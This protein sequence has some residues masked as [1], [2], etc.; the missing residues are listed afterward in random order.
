M[1]ISIVIVTYNSEETINR[2]I[3]SIIR[4]NDIGNELE[5]IVSDNN[6]L[7]RGYLS[8]LKSHFKFENLQVI[9]NPRNGGFGYGNNRGINVSKGDILFFLNPDTVIK[10]ISFRRIIKFYERNNSLLTFKSN[11]NLIFNPEIVFYLPYGI[12]RDLVKNLIIKLLCS[13]SKGYTRIPN[14]FYAMG[15]AFAIKKEVFASIG[16]FDEELF[17]YGE[18]LS[19]KYRLQDRN[20]YSL[21][22]DNEALIVHEGGVSTGKNENTEKYRS[23]RDENIS[24]S[25]KVNLIKYGKRGVAKRMLIGYK[26]EHLIRRIMSKDTQNVDNKIKLLKDIIKEF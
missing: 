24:K 8:G 25:M 22:M 7:N 6:P 1:R 2:C 19:I 5:I 3:E 18:E 16:F 14:I 9:L 23:F 17:M 10:K 13:R 11:N 21:Y 12:L 15:S 26:V 4:N 20:N